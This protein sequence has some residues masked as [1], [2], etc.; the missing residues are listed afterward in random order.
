MADE[1]SFP[2]GASVHNTW[3]GVG[4]ESTETLICSTPMGRVWSSNSRLMAR[5]N[6]PEPSKEHRHA[7]G[8]EVECS[9]NGW[10]C[11][12]GRQGG[13]VAAAREEKKVASTLGERIKR[14]LPFL[15]LVDQDAW[16]MLLLY[17][18]K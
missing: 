14:W 10:C 1:P 12:C 5:E 8:R 11:V 16:Y 15:K 18:S 4:R 13:P 9:G 7:L 2:H 17:M 3:L 6:W